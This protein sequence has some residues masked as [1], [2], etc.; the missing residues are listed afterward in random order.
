MDNTCGTNILPNS[1][2]KYIGSINIIISKNSINSFKVV[3]KY[4]GEEW[5]IS[6][7]NPEYIE[8]LRPM[9]IEEKIDLMQILNN[10]WK[11]L[12]E[13]FNISCKDNCYENTCKFYKSRYIPATPP[14][15]LL[16]PE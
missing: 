8:Y 13:L 2:G 14:N 16:L 6:T 5:I 10:N 3:K 7:N 15:Y 9:T 1:S 11:K 4:T 12:I